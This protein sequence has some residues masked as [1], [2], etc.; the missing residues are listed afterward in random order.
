MSLETQRKLLRALRAKA[1]ILAF[2][3]RNNLLYTLYGKV[4]EGLEYCE[5]AVCGTF[6]EE[7]R[8]WVEPQDM[9]GCGGRSTRRRYVVAQREALRT[10][11]EGPRKIG[12][13][14]MARG[15]TEE[16]GLA[17]MEMYIRHAPSIQGY[18]ADAEE[19]QCSSYASLEKRPL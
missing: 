7:C 15:D 19:E 6:A 5:S 18:G 16:H 12:P 13:Y 17:F 10:G 1:R 3:G 2:L 11:S 14:M 4:Y 9:I 8:G